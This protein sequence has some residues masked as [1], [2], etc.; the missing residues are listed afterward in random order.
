MSLRA[1][2][3]PKTGEDMAGHIDDI[4]CETFKMVRT[5]QCE[6][7]SV[8]GRQAACYGLEGCHGYLNGC[9]CPG[10]VET[11]EVIKAGATEKAG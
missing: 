11:E 8:N 10:C 1:V 9:D 3:K 7:C 5:P 4:P 2:L 6:R